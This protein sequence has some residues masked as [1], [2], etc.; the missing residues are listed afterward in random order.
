MPV[1]QHWYHIGQSPCCLLLYHLGQP[2]ILFISWVCGLWPLLPHNSLSTVTWVR[3]CPILAWPALWSRDVP[4]LALLVRFW[5]VVVIF[6][7]FFFLL[8]NL[9]GLQPCRQILY[10]LSYEGSPGVPHVH[11]IQKRKRE[12]RALWYMAFKNIHLHFFVCVCVWWEL[13]RFMFLAVSKY[14]LQCAQLLSCVLRFSTLWTIAHQT[15]LSMGFLRQEYWSRLPF[16]PPGDLSNPGIKTEFIYKNKWRNRH[17][18]QTYG[19][20]ER[21]GESEMYGKSNI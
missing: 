3:P 2:H 10:Q 1:G 5:P 18:E 12:K 19:H 16:P 11:V 21:G 13:W 20:G 7:F 17:R 15:S 14:I 8:E 9:W 4:A 6:V